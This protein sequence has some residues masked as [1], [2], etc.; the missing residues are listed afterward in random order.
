MSIGTTSLSQTLGQWIGVAGVR[1]R[2]LL[3]WQSGVLLDAIGGGGAEPGLGRGD[4]RRIG[5][6]EIHEKPHLAIGDV[7]AGQ[8]IGSSSR[9]ETRPYTGRRDRQNAAPSGATPLAGF[10]T[11]VGLRPPF[12]TNPA[13]L[14]HP[15]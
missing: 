14:S 2:F 6:A 5:L 13:T 8:G 15:D 10:A 4:G 11:P 3:R 12:V 7:S 1:G 9:E